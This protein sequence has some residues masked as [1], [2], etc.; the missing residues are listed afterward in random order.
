MGNNIIEYL[1]KCHLNFNPEWKHE[2]LLVN[3]RDL[4]T[5][6]RFDLYAIL[7]YIDHKVKG[8]S[9]MQYAKSVY[10]Q[11]TNVI[12]GFSCS[13]K[14]NELKNS[15]EDFLATIDALID[16][17]QNGRYD[18]QRSPIPVD[19]NNVIVDGAHRVCCAAYFKQK[20]R[21]V[22]FVDKDFHQHVTSDFLI[23]NALPVDIADAMA[24][25]A[26]NWHDDLYMLFLWPKAFK[27][28]THLQEANELIEERIPIVY[29]KKLQM[30]YNAIR[31]LMIQIYAH[32]DWVGTVDNDFYNTHVKADEVWDSNGHVE[33]LLVRGKNTQEILNI[34]S[35]VR[36]IY[37]IGLSSIHST[38]NIG[39]TRIAANLIYNKNSIHHLHLGHPTQYAESHHLIENFKYRIK[40]NALDIRDFIIDS[41]MV[42]AVYGIREANDLDYYNL[43]DDINLDYMNIEEHDEHLAYH[44]IGKVDLIVNPA[45]Y[46]V[47]YGVKFISLNRLALFKKNRGE[48]KDINDLQLINTYVSSENKL[49]MQFL[50]M[51]DTFRRKKIIYKKNLRA[52][53]RQSLITLH[54]FDFV[55]SIYRK[56][57]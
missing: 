19:C 53:V 56:F 23:N 38:D 14:G 43:N 16:D 24:L 34:K 7:L 18:A 13:E 50:L 35:E 11:R 52:F 45:N 3:A 1:D 12:T 49:K 55:H 9:D 37:G 28:S 5:H 39:E 20:V 4:L 40:E 25:E 30:S 17:F 6:N 29:K 27:N 57:K 33:F 10:Y 48:K 42:L 46:F 32:M 2:D 8:V 21:I 51:K 54:I 41:S 36:D 22:K 47:Y 26:C 15:F 44:N 31:N